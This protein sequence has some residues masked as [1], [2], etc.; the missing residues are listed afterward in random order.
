[1][2]FCSQC[3]NCLSMTVREG[4]IS[5]ICRA[6]GASTELKKG[7]H[8]IWEGLGTVTKT[9]LFMQ[10]VDPSIHQDPTIATRE[11]HCP[12]C[13]CL[14]KVRYVRYGD[15]LDFLYACP[16]CTRFWTRKGGGASTL[17]DDRHADD[18]QGSAVAETPTQSASA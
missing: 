11:V 7:S 13:E 1:M 12:I 6:C 17:V 18:S 15:A 4:R 8:V 10:W 9:N 3:E 16:E 2:K 5:Q 14:R